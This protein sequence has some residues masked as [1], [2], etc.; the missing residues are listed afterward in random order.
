MI[1]APE[2]VKEAIV[3]INKKG[4]GEKEMEGNIRLEWGS[5]H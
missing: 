5:S 1:N 3:I 2:G 4:L